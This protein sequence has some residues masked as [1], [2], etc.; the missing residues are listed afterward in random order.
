MMDLGDL[1]PFSLIIN[2][3]VISAGHEHDTPG[4]LLSFSLKINRRGY[5]WVTSMIYWVDSGPLLTFS[6]IINR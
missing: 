5:L 1:L 2:D 6:L 3:E 4:V